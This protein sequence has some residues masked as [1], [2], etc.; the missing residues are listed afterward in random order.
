[1][2]YHI[3]D[4]QIVELTADYIEYIYSKYIPNGSLLVT[5]GQSLDNIVIPSEV[6]HIVFDDA[7]NPI[8]VIQ[9]LF[10][11]TVTT[12]NILTVTKELKVGD[13]ISVTIR[14]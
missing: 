4:N 7:S 6:T 11:Y 8:D 2:I 5:N 1:M 9:H 13:I 3:S 10:D 12:G 14:I